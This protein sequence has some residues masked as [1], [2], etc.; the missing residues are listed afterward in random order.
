[1]TVLLD[2]FAALS[3]A[4]GSAGTT[5]STVRAQASQEDVRVFQMH[6]QG[7]DALQYLN[8]SRNNNVEY[9]SNFHLNL[10]FLSTFYI[11][12]NN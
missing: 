12:R 4:Q 3:K 11:H 9:S 1:M 10:L 6:L 2:K 7:G 8:T 5:D